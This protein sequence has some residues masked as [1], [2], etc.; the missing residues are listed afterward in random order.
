[1][2]RK[3][4]NFVI[5][6]F[7]TIGALIAVMAI[8]WLG[9][10]KYLEKGEYYIAYFSESVQGLQV[11]SPVKYLGVEIGRVESID[12][13]PDHQLIEVIM[14]IT[15]EPAEEVD[16]QKVLPTLVAQLKPAGITGIVFIEVDIRKPHETVLLPEFEPASPYPVVA[17]RS[18]GIRQLQM[19]FESAVDKFKEFD[20]KGISE[21]LIQTAEAAE[22]FLAGDKTARIAENVESV[23]KRLDNVMTNLEEVTEEKPVEGVLKEARLAIRDVRSLVGTLNENVKAMQLAETGRQA[24]RLVEGIDRSTR[25]ITLDLRAASENLRRSSETLNGLLERLEASPSDILFS[26]PPETRRKE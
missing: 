18:S 9:A 1:M 11:D 7:V 17:T 8:V 16:R 24:N 5:G 26:A 3:T 21:Q 13:A 4:S 2:A 6:L 23:T 10:T 20:F 25:S 19:G 14:K 15:R 12:L 22:N